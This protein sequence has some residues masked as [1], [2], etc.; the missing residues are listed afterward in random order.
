MPFL[1]IL[2]LALQA[3]AA[4]LGVSLKVQG[5]QEVHATLSGPAA[6]MAAGAF[7]GSIALNGS[8]T[9]LPITGT[10]AQSNGRWRLSLA[11]RYADVPAD[12]V[13][14]F[15]PDAVTYRLRGGVG[16]A[17]REWTGSVPWK[18][19]EVEGGKETGAEFVELKDV[20]LTEL[21]L[22]SSEAAAEVSVRN[23]F[24]FPLKI[25]ETQYTI[26]VEGHEVGGGATQGM[27][28]H[29]AQKNV[30]V[31]PIDLDHASLLSAAGKAL[32]SGGDVAARLRGKLVI[33]LK[34]GDLAVPLDLSG[35]LSGGS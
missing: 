35:H 22:L 32:L 21:T 20:K 24:P 1:P 12:W 11:V 29:P 31:L 8:P 34:G 4:P 13:D 23:P 10:V 26:F 6:E 2:L 3:A 28:L 14:R 18:D 16:G 9:E 19:I 27:I 15:R 33:R 25:A 5:D 17:S 7:H 30:L